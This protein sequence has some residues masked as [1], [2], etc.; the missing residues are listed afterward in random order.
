MSCNREKLINTAIVHRLSSV[1]FREDRV[2][3]VST[4]IRSESHEGSELQDVNTGGWREERAGA[5][6]KRGNRDLRSGANAQAGLWLLYASDSGRTFSTTCRHFDSEN[7]GPTMEAL[8]FVAVLL[9]VVLV[10]VLGTLGTPLPSQEED[11]EMW[12]VDNWKGYPAER[13]I[14]IRLADLLKRSKSQQ[15]HGLMGR[16]SG[17]SQPVRLGRKRNKGEMFVGLMGRRSLG[18]EDVEEEWKSESY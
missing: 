11:G 9:L 18:A 5:A 17:A 10:Q 13:G 16:S 8:K 3:S 2:Y 14:S 1:G 15:F 6:L 7:L 4:H 12:S